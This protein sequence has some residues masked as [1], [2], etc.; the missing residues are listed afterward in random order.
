M[1][2]TYTPAREVAKALVDA[3]RADTV[4]SN[5]GGL[6]FPAWANRINSDDDRVYSNQVELPEDAGVREQLPRI[7]FEVLWQ[8]A[9]FEQEQSGI[10]H[11]PV[12]VYVHV[13]VPRDQEEYGEQLVAQAFLKIRSVLGP[14]STGALSARIIAAELVPTTGVLKDRI[15]A[16][17]GAWEWIAGFRSQNVEVL[18]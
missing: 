11:G 10:L 5:P 3:F 13:V 17:N 8:S 15:P 9:L 16:F 1:T 14:L 2:S 18:V 7:L 6:L 12:N 4:W